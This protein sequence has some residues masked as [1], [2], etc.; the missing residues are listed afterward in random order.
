MLAGERRGRAPAAMRVSG[1]AMPSRGL[2]VVNA[3]DW[4]GFCE[5]TDAIESC[6]A[7]GAI[8]STTAMVHMADSHRAAEL[9]REHERP[10]GLHLNLTQPY[11]APAVP[12]PVR[13]R[14]LRLCAHFATLARR[15][16]TLSPDP[17]VHRLIADGIRDQL[18]EFRERYERE[19]THVDSHHH[20]HVCP[21]VFLSRALARGTRVRQALSFAPGT[22]RRG[23]KGLARG[24][25]QRLLARRFL[26][27]ERFWC[28][29]ELS[30]GDGAVPIAQAAAY[31]V[32]HA[33]EIMVHPSF[34]SD[35][36]V[37]RS[38]AWLSVL[39]DA[40]LASYTALRRV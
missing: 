36:T 19:P 16:W 26:T 5:G 7:I 12:A 28:A 24:A 33:I 11:D 40:P 10:T 20:V 22:G 15:R 23:V 39:H 21:D 37:L 2:L 32:T 31:A 29:G 30:D 4:G 35:I 6:F 34:A 14:Q 17:R 9:A 27:T 8:S 1:G 25:K 18:E 38:E 3:D 13:E